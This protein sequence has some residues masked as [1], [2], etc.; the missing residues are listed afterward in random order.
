MIATFHLL[1][2]GG[3]ILICGIII[4]VLVVIGA[5]SVEAWHEF[6][7]Q[8]AG[9]HAAGV[10]L[11]QTLPPWDDP[12]PLPVTLPDLPALACLQDGWVRE[13]MASI[14]EGPA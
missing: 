6:G 4:P 11:P 5:M 13:V 1:T 2:V 8:P 3:F 12:A 14:E 9:R 10:W 7:P